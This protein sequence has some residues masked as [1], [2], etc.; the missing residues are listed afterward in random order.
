MNCSAVLSPDCLKEEELGTHWTT[1][2]DASRP[3][4]VSSARSKP[5]AQLRTSR[6][7]PFLS[8]VF[9]CVGGRRFSSS[10]ANG[11]GP[12]DVLGD[13]GLEDEEGEGSPAVGSTPAAAPAVVALLRP[14]LA[15]RLGV[16]G[17]LIEP[18]EASVPNEDEGM[19]I[20]RR[21][22]FEMRASEGSIREE[23]MVGCCPRR[24]G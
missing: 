21:C 4:I 10:A 2:I 20:G 7:L 13:G 18:D 15:T 19:R 23:V 14:L 5:S 8:S 3:P 22:V 9:D 12:V 1:F 17:G 24:T 16:A 6:P 11:I